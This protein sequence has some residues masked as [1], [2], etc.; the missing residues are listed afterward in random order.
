MAFELDDLPEAVISVVALALASIPFGI[1]WGM[2]QS[3]PLALVYCAGAALYW[4]LVSVPRT[5]RIAASGVPF[6]RMNA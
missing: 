2:V 4:A 6:R 5:A 1:C 3:P